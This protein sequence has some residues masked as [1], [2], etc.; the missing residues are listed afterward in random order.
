ME[1][2]P[3]RPAYLGLGVD[4]ISRRAVQARVLL[5]PDR[6]R[7]CPRLCRVDRL[8]DVKGLCQIGRTAVVASHF[9][10]FGEE[11]CLRG[12]NG[13]GTIFFSGC[14]LRC[15]FCQNHDISWEVRGERVTP[16]RLAQMMLELQDNGCHNINFV[17]PEHVVPQILEALPHAI[18]AGLRLPI[19]YNT[20]SYDSLD[21]LALMDGIVD[22]YMPDAK[23]WSRERARRF[24]RMPDYPEVMRATIPEMGR[25]VGKLVLDHD[26]LAVR[27]LL[28][29]H[30]VMPGMFG[31]TA[32]IL[33]WI[34]DV[35]GPDTYVDL[36]AQSTTRPA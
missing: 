9:A 13:S 19:V 15:V 7:V 25:Q 1:S 28:V 32:E 2:V 14:N 22:I 10:H 5:G 20:S 11:N 24:L 34:A 18:D 16:Q 36:M 3:P 6:C 30:L 31:E 21:S 23:V 17:T 8:H 26:G 33:R 27:G 12:W 4:E 35:L 29:R